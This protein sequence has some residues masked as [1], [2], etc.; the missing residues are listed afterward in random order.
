M[1]CENFQDLIMNHFEEKNSPQETKTLAEHLLTCE[2]CRELYT[3][4]DNAYEAEII[5]APDTL[6][7]NIMS[8]IRKEQQKSPSFRLIWGISALFIGLMLLI[9]PYALAETVY[10]SSV[11]DSL[12]A[13]AASF[14][15]EEIGVYALL[16]TALTGAL[17]YV[18]HNGEKLK[19]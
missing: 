6:T 10:S 3:T 5:Q 15:A 2:E 13:I 7:Q 18:L 11:L 1:T 12:A 9:N 14:P 17:L 4:M 19:T 8:A 16:L